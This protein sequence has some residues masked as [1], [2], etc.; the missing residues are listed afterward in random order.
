MC[1]DLYHSGLL[2]FIEILI[3]ATPLA[4]DCTYYVYK[5]DNLGAKLA[6]FHQLT[7][8]SAVNC[9]YTMCLNGDFSM[10]MVGWMEINQNF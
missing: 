4:A 10:S 9:L 5:L 3:K 7:L 8:K 2:S 6:K 1:I